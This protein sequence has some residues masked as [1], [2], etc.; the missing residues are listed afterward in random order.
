MSEH[1]AT[2]R[3]RSV[4]ET[5]VT[6][7][8]KQRY[9]VVVMGA[10]AVGKTC[11]VQRMLY[12]QFV[13]DYK[14]TVEQLYSQRYLLNGTS[15]TL[16]LLDTSGAYEFPAMRKLSISTADAFI[17]VYSVDDAASF[18]E[19]SRL[20]L[21]IIKQKQNELTPIVIVGN[22]ADVS[23]RVVNF[24]MAESTALIDWE[25]GYVEAS[26]KDNVNVTAIFN[27]LLRQTNV[28]HGDLQR[29]RDSEPSSSGRKTARKHKPNSCIVA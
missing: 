13:T 17:L 21:Q 4:S 14:A 18:D 7:S 19:V 27:E 2:S 15:I 25:N 29:R 9:R 6:R 5:H 24:E 8:V 22:K 10:A 23:E 20:R 3:I 26:A 28:E 16:E 12:E 11:I 1:T